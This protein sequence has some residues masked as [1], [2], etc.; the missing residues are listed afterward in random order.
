LTPLFLAPTGAEAFPTGAEPLAVAADPT[1]R[2]LYV[3]NG[4]N[5][6]TGN[7][8]PSISGFT[9]KADG[10]LAGMAGSPFSA[11]R[12]TAGLTVEPSGRLLYATNFNQRAR[13]Q[14]LRS[15]LS[16]QQDAIERLAEMPGLGVTALAKAT[17][18]L[19]APQLGGKE[20]SSRSVT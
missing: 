10:T 3:S 19:R 1:G 12:G 17:A 11:G 5:P 4:Q 16:Q 13:S 20:A 6:I 2:F 14:L 9:V 15:L 18:E 8:E 7:Y